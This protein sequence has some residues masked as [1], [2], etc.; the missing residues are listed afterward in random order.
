VILVIQVWSFVD[1]SQMLGDLW[2]NSSRNFQWI[3][4]S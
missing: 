3:W 4:T 2:L 1:S